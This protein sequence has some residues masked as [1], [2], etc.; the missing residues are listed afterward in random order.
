MSSESKILIKMRFCR[1]VY[2][3]NKKRTETIM[4]GPWIYLF[5]I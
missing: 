1:K 4:A 3:Y 2:K 5:Q